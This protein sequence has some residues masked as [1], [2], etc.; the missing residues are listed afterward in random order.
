[1][2]DRRHLDLRDYA[3]LVIAALVLFVPGRASL[4][5]LDRDESRYMQATSQMLETHNFIDVRFQD[6]PRYLQPAGIY[7]LQSASVALLSSAEARQPWA[8]RMPALIGAV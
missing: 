5:P 4:P 7:W 6:Q 2:N 1:M 3:V 8:Y